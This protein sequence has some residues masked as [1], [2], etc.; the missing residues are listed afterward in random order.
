MKL[1]EWLDEEVGRAT[2]LAAHC[3]GISLSAISQWRNNGIPVDRMKSVRDFTEG[4]VTLEEMI[5]DA[6]EQAA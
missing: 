1:N 5:P 2:K 3:G 4:L 6:Q